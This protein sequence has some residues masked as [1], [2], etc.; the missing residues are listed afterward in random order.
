MNIEFNENYKEICIYTGKVDDEYCFKVEVFWNSVD[1]RY[2]IKRIVFN[3]DKNVDF[4][5]EL[6]EKAIRKLVREWYYND[7]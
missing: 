5:T 7:E 3:I 1:R 2:I 4:N 6:A